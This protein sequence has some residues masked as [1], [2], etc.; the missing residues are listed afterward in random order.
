MSLMA[1]G[2]DSAMLIKMRSLATAVAVSVL[3]AP[4]VFMTPVMTAP[5]DA[6]I[7]KS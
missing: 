4:S 3:M 2:A 1:M 7:V 5:K 6:S